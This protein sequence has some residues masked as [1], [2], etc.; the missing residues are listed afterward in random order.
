MGVTPDSALNYIKCEG[1]GRVVNNSVEFWILYSGLA[2]ST[3]SKH[4]T[5]LAKDLQSKC[6]QGT[7]HPIGSYQIVLSNPE[8]TDRDDHED[9]ENDCG[10]N[11]FSSL[12]CLNKITRYKFMRVLSLWFC[13]VIVW[14]VSTIL[15]RTCFMRVPSMWF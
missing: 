1:I 6:L 12:M 5:S 15:P 13:I 7:L 4:L 14:H 9:I 10:F 2:D 8:C 11:N 3:L